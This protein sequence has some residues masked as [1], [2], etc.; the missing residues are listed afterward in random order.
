MSS[1]SRSVVLVLLLLWQS[2]SCLASVQVKGQSEILA[3]A[4]VHSQAMDHHHHDDKSLHLD[5][6]QG[7]DGHQHVHDGLQVSAVPLTPWQWPLAL[8]ASDRPAR[9]ALDPLSVY[10]EG[11][12]R[13][14]QSPPI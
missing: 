2:L 9:A 5:D 11:P 8:T 10:L 4:L 13:P 3:H 7:G 1:R 14:P 12:L 6:A